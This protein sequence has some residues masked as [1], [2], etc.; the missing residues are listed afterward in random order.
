MA[1]RLGE[2]LVEAGLVSV[3]AIDS[4]LQQQKITGHRLGDCLL[5]LGLIQEV[6][7]LRFLA[8][9]FKTRF[10]SADKLA[11]AKIPPEVLDKVPVRMC[12]AQA[13]LPLALDAERKILSIVM[14]EPQNLAL[15]KEVTLITEMEEVFAYVGVRSAILA[16]IKK[17][18][19]GD[20]TAFAALES[21]GVQALRNDVATMSGAYENESR[22]GPAPS[23]GASNPGQSVLL[24]GSARRH[25]TSGGKGTSSR[26]NPTQLREAL[27]AVRGTIGETD[28]VETLN[29]LI[30]LMEMNRKEF[31]GHS[32]Q[33]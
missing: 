30:G 18:Y 11:K 7:L 4:A 15:V 20:H 5:E 6:A 13:F 29:I 12:E 24:D 22:V 21:G 23:G 25:E 9:E 3:E 32:A 27:G 1:K 16:G 8:A 10:V 2:Q 33:V 14:A 17:H 19:Y 26:V 28:F 31:R